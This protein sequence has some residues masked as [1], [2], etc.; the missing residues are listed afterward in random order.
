MFRIEGESIILSRG[1]TG[2][3]T[4]GV[5][6]FSFSANDRALFTVRDSNDGSVKMRRELPIVNNTVTITFVNS[7]TDSLASGSY[8]W[9]I[10]FV[11]NP[12]YT[13]G[14]IDDGDEV[15]TPNLPMELR[16]LPTVGQI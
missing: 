10:R 13:D 16:L 5:T 4:I 14:E 6:G 11:I 2:E 12:H 7:D 3:V 9:D 15:N 8:Q 1:D